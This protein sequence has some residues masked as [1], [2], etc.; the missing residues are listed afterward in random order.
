M[1]PRQQ[2]AGIKMSRA[3]KRLNSMG[4]DKVNVYN[5]GKRFVGFAKSPP[6]SMPETMSLEDNYESTASTLSALSASLRNIK[7]YPREIRLIQEKYPFPIYDQYWDFSTIK[8]I[9]IPVALVIASEY[10][11]VTLLRQ[12][13]PAAVAIETW[14]APVRDLLR[15]IGFL[16]LCHVEPQGPPVGIVGSQKVR[17]FQACVDA[18]G[19][20]IGSFFND[21]GLLVEE[22]DPQIYG[23]LFEA[24]L[25][26]RNH[27]YA[28]SSSP[29]VLHRWWMTGSYDAD[30]R[31]LTVAVYDHGMS[32]PVSLA[33]DET[34]WSLVVIFRDMWNWI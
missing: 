9:S 28:N 5:S 17:R 2:V 14:H 34:D 27:A 13:P 10:D 3:E 32:I 30:L 1:T 15:S 7:I 22:L 29:E 33:G 20:E 6:K 21:L 11:R 24:I 19:E 23:G 12:K 25:N 16:E 31:E 4:F 26:T 8:V 18:V